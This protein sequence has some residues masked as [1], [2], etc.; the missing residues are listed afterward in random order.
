MQQSLSKHNGMF[1]KSTIVGKDTAIKTTALGDNKE[2]GMVNDN[3]CKIIT[4][5]SLPS[6]T[7]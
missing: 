5:Y 7:H 6:L 1:V 4:N 2:L 3:N